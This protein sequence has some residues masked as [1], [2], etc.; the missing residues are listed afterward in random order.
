MVRSQT[1]AASADPDFVAGGGDAGQGG[2]DGGEDCAAKSPADVALATS[3]T[4]PSPKSEASPL[5]SPSAESEEVM[6]SMSEL[7]KATRDVARLDEELQESQE[8][9]GFGH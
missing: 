3:S 5:P 1:S 2:S 6:V 7:T 4:A 8:L 9:V